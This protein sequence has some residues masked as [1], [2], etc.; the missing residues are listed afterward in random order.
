MALR[1]VTAPTAEP[2][3]V[4]DAKL[5]LRIDGDDDNSMVSALI[6]AAREYCE[7]FQN[8]AYVTQTLELTLDHF[9]H[10]R[11]RPLMYDLPFYEEARSVRQ[12]R[13]HH[14]MIKLLMPPIQSV[15]TITY[16]DDTGV[17]TTLDPSTYIVDTDTEPGRIVPVHGQHWPNVCLQP[18]NGVR[19]RYVAGYGDTAAAVPSAVKQSMMMLVDHWYENR[20]AVG[21]VGDEVALAVKAL[22]TLQR[23]VPT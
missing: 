3:S 14:N 13:H 8:R 19:V 5:Y 22:L 10:H 15:A 11:F 2:V 20:E 18:I 1:V 21:K 17:T 7:A 6:V 16:T 23:V 12:K 4:D 9:P